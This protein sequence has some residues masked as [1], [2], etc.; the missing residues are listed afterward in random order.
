[1]LEPTQ[2]FHYF[3]SRGSMSSSRCGWVFGQDVDRAVSSTNV[4]LIGIHNVPRCIRH[5]RKRSPMLLLRLYS[6]VA[7]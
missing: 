4:D 5:L 6:A 7:M 2:R 1:M 3:T